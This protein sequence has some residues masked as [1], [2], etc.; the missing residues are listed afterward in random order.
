MAAKLFFA[1][2]EPGYC[3][4]YYKT[5]SGRLFCVQEE[6]KGVYEFYICSDDEPFS[7]VNPAGC[8]FEAIPEPSEYDKGFMQYLKEN[9]AVIVDKIQA[10]EINA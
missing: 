5:K 3:R 8:I 6:M 7:P 9:G 10:E 4:V 2:T 1:Y